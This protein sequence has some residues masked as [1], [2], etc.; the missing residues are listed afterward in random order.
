MFPDKRYELVKLIAGKAA[1]FESVQAEIQQMKID[2]SEDDLEL[3]GKYK[4]KI[5]VKENDTML[6]DT[7]IIHTKTKTYTMIMR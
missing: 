3:Y 2:I 5:N 7:V 4:A 1:F 6:G